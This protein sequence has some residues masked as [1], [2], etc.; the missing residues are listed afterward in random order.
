M[1]DPQTVAHEI[2]YPWRAYRASE[3]RN[4]FERTYR[5][6]FLTIWHVDPEKDGSDDS[7]GW[8]YPKLTKRQ[9]ERL[10]SLAWDEGRDPYFLRCGRKEWAG[11]RAE[12]EALYRGLVLQVARFLG[13]DVSFDEAAQRAA[14]RIHR[15]D[16]IDHATTF[17]FVPGYHTNGKEDTPAHREE[18]FMGRIVGIAAELLH[19]RRHWYQH[20]KW[21]VWHWKLQVHPMQAFKRWAFSRCAGCG[22]RFAWDY[23][24]TTYNWNGTGPRWF[25]SER[26]VYHSQC[27]REVSQKA[28]PPQETP[29]AVH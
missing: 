17:C 5:R 2:R 3:A 15:A 13:L 4:D 19:E 18:V 10:Q 21:H 23:S 8:S 11:T 27:A 28:V 14:E 9:R 16:C 26:G 7:C 20:P 1:H 22:T 6:A 24:P 29:Q 25:R 12:A